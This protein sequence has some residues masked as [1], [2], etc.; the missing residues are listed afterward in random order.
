[1]QRELECRDQKPD[2]SGILL[3]QARWPNVW[4][5]CPEEKN[6]RIWFYG[7]PE[8]Y[9]W[10]VDK[11]FHCDTDCARTSSRATAGCGR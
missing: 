4:E 2:W 1:M 7:L 9:W 5:L 11:R 6:R 3:G 8:I 10:R